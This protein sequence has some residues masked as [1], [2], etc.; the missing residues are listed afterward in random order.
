MLP[1]TFPLPVA[2][3]PPPCIPRPNRGGAGGQD[4][5]RHPRRSRSSHRAP[6]R[7]APAGPSAP[8]PWRCSTGSP[9]PGC[10]S[11]PVPPPPG[12]EVAGRELR[13]VS[14]SRLPGS[15]I[16]GLRKTAAWGGGPEPRGAGLSVSSL[17]RGC[18]GGP[19]PVWGCPSSRR[20]GE[21]PL[22]SG[23]QG[24]ARGV[25]AAKAGLEPA[26][27][28]GRALP[29]RE[30]AEPEAGCVG[31][32]LERCFPSVCPHTVLFRAPHSPQE[33]MVRRG[34]T[35]WGCCWKPP[36]CRE[37]RGP[38]ALALWTSWLQKG[39]KARMKQ[40]TTYH[41]ALSL[42]PS[43]FAG[44]KGKPSNYPPSPTPC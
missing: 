38:E 27:P 21:H 30:R 10:D 29:A 31:A 33:V 17:P 23:L 36:V 7:P 35:G 40:G 18:A 28:A 44:L 26:G 1:A 14:G 6:P 16:K 24:A 37:N 22:I 20:A 32:G 9:T 43:N 3:G 15:D 11:G 34:E 2:L 8:R 42:F 39:E 19:G 25:G 41:F 12:P 5:T 4:Q 13:S